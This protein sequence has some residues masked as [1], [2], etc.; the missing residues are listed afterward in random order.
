MANTQAVSTTFKKELL[1][2]KHAFGLPPVRATSVKDTFRAALYLASATLNAAT[3]TYST[4]GEVT[5]A[6]YTAGGITVTN[7]I[8]PAN[9]T[10]T[11]GGTAG[12]W[13]PSTQLSWSGITAS[14]FDAV[15]IYNSTQGNSVVGIWTFGSQSVTAGTFTLNMPTNDADNAL[16][17]IV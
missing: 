4:T 7:A 10:V 16:L 2:G 8:E 11:A 15:E 6:G 3:S 1:T 5:G 9:G 14:A 17:R 12:Y 13:T